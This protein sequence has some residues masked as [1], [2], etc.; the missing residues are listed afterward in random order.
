ATGALRR[1]RD[2]RP[3]DLVNIMVT[4][5][6]EDRASVEGSIWRA[7]AMPPRFAHG[8]IVDARIVLVRSE[9]RL[10][11]VGAIDGK[12]RIELVHEGASGGGWVKAKISRVD[13][14]SAWILGEVTA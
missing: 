2:F 12:Y 13:A 11:C 10:L 1:A 7:A 9:P 4:R 8:D 14:V 3:G 5:V 6:Q